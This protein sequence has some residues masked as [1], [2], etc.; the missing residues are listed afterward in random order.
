MCQL[1]IV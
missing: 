1:I